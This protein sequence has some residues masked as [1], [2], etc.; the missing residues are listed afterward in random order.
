MFIKAIYAYLTAV[1][2]HGGLT[3]AAMASTTS[4][5]VVGGL[6]FTQLFSDFT[7]EVRVQ[8]LAWVVVL[9]LGCFMLYACFTFVNLATGLWAAK[10]ENCK[11]ANPKKTYIQIEKLWRTIWKSLGVILLTL[12]ISFLA[13]MVST[14]GFNGSFWLAMWFLIAFWL[15]ANS[16]EFYSI[17]QNIE[18]RFGYKPRIFA[19]WDNATQ[20]FEKKITDKIE[21]TS[22]NDKN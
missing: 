14:A 4:A 2:A 13:M 22:F 3:K 6:R 18:R 10:Y 9:Q 11:S 19:F 21:E 12:T 5:I 16:Y 7:Q 17:G 15:L 8:D 1:F 20:I